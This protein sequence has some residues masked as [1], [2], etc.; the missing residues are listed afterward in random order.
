MPNARD[1]V[2]LELLMGYASAVY[3]NAGIAAAIQTIEAARAP[4]PPGSPADTC[5]LINRGL[6]EHR[7][8]R[9]DLAIVTLTQ[10]YREQRREP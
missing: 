9:E 7:Q 10:A 1:P 3:D 8:G 5:L 6:L 4:Q 2:H